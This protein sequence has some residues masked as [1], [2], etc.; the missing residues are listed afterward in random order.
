MTC[1]SIRSVPLWKPPAASLTPGLGPSLA[2]L[3]R[4]YLVIGATLTWPMSPLAVE[5]PYRGRY[6]WSTPAMSALAWYS[7]ATPASPG[8]DLR[9]QNDCSQ[10]AAQETRSRGNENTQGRQRNIPLAALPAP[11]IE[12]G[13]RL[14]ATRKLPRI[15]TL[16]CEA[17][18]KEPKKMH[19]SGGRVRAVH[20]QWL[21]SAVQIRLRS[22][23]SRVGSD[24]FC[25]SWER[26]P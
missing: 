12:I 16:E 7:S 24:H 22:S 9:F 15:R 2:D 21:R 18:H 10:M 26:G 14:P 13:S 23:F 1:T 4:S 8:G 25:P 3:P 19:E 11:E 17:V 20:R 6:A 5:Q